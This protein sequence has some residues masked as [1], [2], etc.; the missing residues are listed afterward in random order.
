LF[1]NV[2]INKDFK[3]LAG[4]SL[5]QPMP[6]ALQRRGMN[7]TMTTL[8]KLPPIHK[9]CCHF[10]AECGDALTIDFQGNRFTFIVS[11]GNDKIL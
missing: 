3:L 7:C 5:P 11:P 8:P 2:D 4:Q 6:L 1:R 10:D 9:L